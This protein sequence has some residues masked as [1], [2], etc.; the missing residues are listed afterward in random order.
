MNNAK[1]IYTLDI[2]RCIAILFVV[3]IHVLQL[4][5]HFYWKWLWYV[6]YLGVDIFFAL[7]GFLIGNIII[8]ACNNSSDTFPSKKVILFLYRRLMRTAPL[9]FLFLGINWIINT[10]Y[11]RNDLHPDRSYLFWCQNLLKVPDHFFGESWSLCVEEWFYLSASILLSVFLFCMQKINIT[12]YKKLILFCIAYVI[13][14][15]IY[16]YNFADN[17]YDEFKITIF[18]LDA[19][20]YGLIAAAIHRYHPTFF[21][22]KAMPVITIAL[23]ISGIL[24]FLLASKIGIY[25]SLYYLI[26]GVGLALSVVVMRNMNDFFIERFY[27]VIPIFFSKISYSM[28]LVNLPVIALIKKYLLS[29]R[30]F[31]FT[32]RVCV[33]F[34]IITLVSFVCHYFI[35]TPILKLRDRLIKIS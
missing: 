5:G 23:L 28:Y 20:A 6:A 34:I 21:K 27:H 19:I 29:G 31:N 26:M 24:L 11:I 16:R 9:Y 12:I 8:S 3:S 25:Y 15:I 35:E 1:N 33:S 10:I 30:E 4:I 18:R 17:N 32:I 2:V 22:W 13:V 14:I 7:S